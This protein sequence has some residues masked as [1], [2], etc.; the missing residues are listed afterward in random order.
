MSRWIFGGDGRLRSDNEA[1]R[2]CIRFSVVRPLVPRDAGALMLFAVASSGRFGTK[3]TQKLQLF[4]KMVAIRIMYLVDLFGGLETPL[5]NP[6][7]SIV[8]GPSAGFM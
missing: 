3:G 4:L 6:G 5:K 2:D 1:D 8:F 7:T